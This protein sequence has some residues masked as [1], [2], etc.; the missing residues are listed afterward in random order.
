MHRDRQKVAGTFS[1]LVVHTANMGDV[2]SAAGLVRALADTRGG[3]EILVRSP[4]RGL[5]AGEVGIRE[6]G[7]DQLNQSG[8]YEL[9]LDLDSS[10]TSRKIIREVKANR[11]VG[12]YLN[13]L[14]RL[15]YWNL[16]D[17]QV[18][19]HPVDHIVRDYQVLSEALEL[20]P[21]ASP[22]LTP[23]DL[24]AHLSEWLRPLQ[25][26]GRPIVVLA[27]EAANPIRHLPPLLVD[28]L[29]DQLVAR[30]RAV[31]MVGLDQPAMQRWCARHPDWAYWRPL[32]LA[33]VK[34]LFSHARVFIGP[35]S[36]PM[37]LACALQMQVAALFG[38]ALTSKCGPLQINGKIIEKS[39]PCRPCNQN[40]PCPYDRRCLTTI[41]A[42]EVLQG[43][44]V[45]DEPG[46]N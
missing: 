31:V 25:N 24:P 16:Y 44:G 10:Q 6:I 33:A 1:T 3:V 20:G 11:K 30:G 9:C 42:T 43:L 4:F 29:I 36:G 8:P 35:D 12:R 7:E 13:T 26:S 2:V 38:P 5:F 18:P 37:H 46:E 39:F 21:L 28:D 22:R 15:K 23:L 14:R 34:A 17:L 19:K 40:K 45:I 27:P 32:Q 41:T